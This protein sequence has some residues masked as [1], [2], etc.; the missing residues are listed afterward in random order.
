MSHKFAYKWYLKDGYPAPGIE[1]HGC[2]VF[3]TFICGGGSSMGYKLAGYN[4]L[5]GVE[6]DPRISAVY[7]ENHHPDYL[8]TMDLRE[9]NKIPNNEL[10]PELFNI[11]LLDGS[12]PC[13]TFSTAGQ[14]EKAWGKKK[15]FAEGQ[16][17]QTLD[18]LVFVYCDTIEKLRPKIFLLENVSGLVKGNGKIYTKKIV[19]RLTRAG[20]WVQVFLLNAATMGVPQERERTF[21]IGH[22]EEYKIPPLVLNFNEEPILFREI[23]DHSN[24]GDINSLS[25]Q[26]RLIFQNLT[27][28]DRSF[29]S[30]MIRVVGRESGFGQCIFQPHKVAPTITTERDTSIL[31]EYP[32]R[33]TREEISYCCT[34]PL[35]YKCENRNTYYWLVGMS[36][37][38]IM[39]AQIS[40]QIYKQ[41]LKLIKDND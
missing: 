4:H 14:R 25:P 16:A 28:N 39:T 13:S 15:K 12:P 24:K 17:Y 11:D 36:V 21:I 27:P 34:F 38:P 9:F 41:W 8:Y 6:I 5:G 32:R 18:D 19:E 7:K 37:P 22:K 33:I 20:Y 26:M 40:Y 30:V 35:D 31:A 10:P 23:T 1:K 2:K 29:K 3:G